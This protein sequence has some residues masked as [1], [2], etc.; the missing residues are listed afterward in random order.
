MPPILVILVRTDTGSWLVSVYQKVFLWLKAALGF[1]RVPK[2]PRH[3]PRIRHSH[4]NQNLTNRWYMTYLMRNLRMGQGTWRQ[5]IGSHLAGTKLMAYPTADGYSADPGRFAGAASARW[6]D[7]S[8][9]AGRSSGG[10]TAASAT[11]PPGES[12]AD[13]AANPAANPH[14]RCHRLRCRLSFAKF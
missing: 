13:P 11:R 5:P 10:R 4:H 8:W 12:A 2:D 9:P 7:Y 14:S 1:S 6:S 3:S